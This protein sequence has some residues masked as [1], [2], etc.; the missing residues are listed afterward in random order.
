VYAF[1]GT[2]GLFC[3]DFDGKPVWKHSFGVFTSATGWGTAAS[4]FVYEDLVIQNYDNDGPAAAP[5]GVKAADVAPAALVAL[6]RDTGQD[7][8]RT[9]RSRGGGFGTPRLVTVAGGRID[10]VL[11]GPDG[12]VGYDPKTGK[13]RWRC[14]RFDRN[15]QHK[16]GEPMPVNDGEFL[17]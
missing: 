7:R 9:R 14:L 4:P 10:L 1:F 8:W 2:P 3:Y 11:N 16:F 5:P 6:D 13:E 15:E 12:V 17:Y